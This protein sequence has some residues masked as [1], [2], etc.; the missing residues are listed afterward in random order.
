[1][2][3]RNLLD[4]LVGVGERER[5]KRKRTAVHLVSWLFVGMVVLFVLLLLGQFVSRTMLSHPI[6][7]EMDK[8][9]MEVHK[10]ERIQINVL[11]GSGRKGIAQKF[12]DFL[13]ARKF[14]VVHSDNFTDTN[15]EHTYIVDRMHD[16]ASA[17]KIA[18]A[19]GVEDK[20]VRT[21]VDTEEYVQ[22]D[23]V[24]GKDYPLLKPMK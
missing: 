2:A 4:R 14:D 20:F 24:I 18:Y 3:R 7:G 16:S 15:V 12:T 17:R 11:N 10:G 5:E 1:M 21:E 6:S 13:R 8:A 22:A 23:I 19:L 9:A